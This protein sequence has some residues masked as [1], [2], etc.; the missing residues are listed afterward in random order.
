MF[1]S[2]TI[3]LSVLFVAGLA[4]CTRNKT[5]PEP[6]V[7]PPKP[8]LA[9]SDSVFY[10]SPQAAD[11]IIQPTS[12]GAGQ[13]IGF[14][15]GI[16]IDPLTGTINVSKTEAGLKYKVSFIATGKTDTLVTYVTIAGINYLDGFYNL[17]T[18][19]SVIRPVYNATPGKSIPGINGGSAFDIGAG[20]NKN[21]CKVNI[22][23]GQINLAETVRNGVF[24][25]TP[26]NNERKEF[27]LV[28]SIKDNS[29]L[30]NVNLK[31]KLY[32]FDTVNDI[33]PE[34]YAII[35]ERQ[36]TMFLNGLPPPVAAQAKVAKPRPPC[37]F[38][39]GR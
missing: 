2:T 11:Y 30:A 15:D 26:A 20:C 14:P 16:E 25:N 31:V 6:P 24:G 33:T 3:L 21:G 9:Y 12:T 13:Y 32:Y 27:D 37:I 5:T 4:A 29:N 23:N 38:I 39:V 8:K 18:A 19:D 17:S 36:G 7:E 1:R 10:K 28:Y 35:A 22:T 34:A